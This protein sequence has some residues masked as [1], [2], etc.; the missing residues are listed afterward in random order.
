MVAMASHLDFDITFW[1]LYEAMTKGCV[2]N[3]AAKCPILGVA[4]HL[5][6]L[7]G[8]GDPVPLH[9]VCSG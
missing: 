4:G 5:F 2:E 6:I 9:M 1:G 8:V 3:S 7:P